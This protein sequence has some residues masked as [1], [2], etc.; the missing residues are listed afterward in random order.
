M[1]EDQNRQFT[2][3]YTKA[4]KVYVKILHIIYH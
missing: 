3:K 1:S 2:R 4:K